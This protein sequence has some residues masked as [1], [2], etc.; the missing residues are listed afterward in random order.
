VLNPA[1]LAPVTLTEA[2]VPPRPAPAVVDTLGRKVM[3][4]GLITVNFVV[5]A[6]VTNVGVIML[7]VATSH[8]ETVT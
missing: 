8:P 1:V 5:F 2:E 6:K 3:D 4:V 7:Y